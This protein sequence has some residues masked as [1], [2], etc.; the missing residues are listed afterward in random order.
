MTKKGNSPDS[1]IVYFF[2]QVIQSP[3]GTRLLD[4]GDRIP[5]VPW[6]RLERMVVSPNEESEQDNNSLPVSFNYFKLNSFHTAIFVTL[7]AI[8]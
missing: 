8:S 6:D 5:I 7:L 2:P 1:L 3:G 4:V